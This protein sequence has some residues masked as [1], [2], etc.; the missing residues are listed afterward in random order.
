MVFT[1]V[2]RDSPDV[3]VTLLGDAHIS[4]YATWMRPQEDESNL[5]WLR[6]HVAG[7]RPW[8]VGYYAG[9]SDLLAEPNRA[10]RCFTASNWDRLRAVKARYD[11]D[12][13]FFDY[14]GLP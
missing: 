4:S 9:E 13:R 10:E 6:G 3:A 14:P 5:T 12:D 1:P 11:P 2:P 7:L 8:A